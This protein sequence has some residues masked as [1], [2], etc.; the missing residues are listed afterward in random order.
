MRA[1]R[2]EAG[3]LEIDERLVDLRGR[4]GVKCLERRSGPRVLI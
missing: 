2:A 1:K 3:R 4:R